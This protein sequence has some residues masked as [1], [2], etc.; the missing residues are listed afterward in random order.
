MKYKINNFFIVTLLLT[1]TSCVKPKN[2][3]LTVVARKLQN[4]FL[5]IQEK[6]GFNLVKIDESIN[7]FDTFEFEYKHIVTE[8]DIARINKQT[9]YDL[10][11]SGYARRS[12]K[13]ILV[14]KMSNTTMIILGRVM[15]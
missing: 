13:I 5:Y 3:V 10:N 12:K 9:T 6:D 4:E 8:E 15:C 2:V 11:H 14:V 7:I 1:I